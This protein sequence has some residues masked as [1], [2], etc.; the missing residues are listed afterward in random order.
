MEEYLALAEGGQGEVI[1]K[2]SRFIAQTAAVYSEEEASLFIEA[3]RK[4][5]YDARHNCFAY[6][7]GIGSQPLLR[8][9][10]DG[11]P[12]GTAGKPILEV[13]QGSG[14]CNICIVVTRYFGG[15]LL[16]TGGL[17]RAYTEAAKAGIAGSTVRW[18]R[19]LA[20]AEITLDYADLGKLQ[21]L[22][23]TADGKVTDTS[24]TDKVVLQVQVYAPD[25]ERLAAAVTEATGGRAVT[26]KKGE[27]F[28]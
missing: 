24:Y 17:V 23:G 19:R 21:Y 28:G 7:I 18:K 8:C 25:Y 6:S 13:I 26:E 9:S 22:I 4:K 10:D 15:V 20:E 27:V 1:E 16:G 2:K 3:I 11:E 14:I 5:H 12:Q